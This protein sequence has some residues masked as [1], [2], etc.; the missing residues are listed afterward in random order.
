MSKYISCVYAVIISVFVLFNFNC[1]KVLLP[2]DSDDHIE[3]LQ[4]NTN[5]RVILKVLDNYT[6]SPIAG[7]KISIVGVDSSVCNSNGIVIFDSIKVGSYLVGCEKNGN[8]NTFKNLI[9]LL[10]PIVILF[11]LYANQQTFCLWH[12]K[13]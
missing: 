2:V 5:A 8:E 10:I 9:W 7:V 11:R 3:Y 12:A 1:E 6:M 13:E 4:G